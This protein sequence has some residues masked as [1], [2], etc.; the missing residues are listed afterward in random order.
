MRNHVLKV[1]WRREPDGERDWRTMYRGDCS[2]GW[3]TVAESQEKSV[4][5]NLIDDHAKRSQAASVEHESGQY[6]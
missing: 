2:C 3:E 5:V 1:E 6:A 4:I